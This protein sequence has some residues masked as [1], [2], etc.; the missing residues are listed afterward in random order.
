LASPA[1]T[2]GDPAFAEPAI[3]AGTLRGEE[4]IIAGVAMLTAWAIA[5]VREGRRRIHLTAAAGVRRETED[6]WT[7][8]WLAPAP[9]PR[10]SGWGGGCH[11]C[12]R[13]ASLVQC[14]G[15]RAGYCSARCQEGAWE[16]HR[17]SC[18]WNPVAPLY[19]APAE[20]DEA[21][22]LRQESLAR[23][24]RVLR[25]TQQREEAAL[26]DVQTRLDFGG[27]TTGGGSGR[28][29]E[30]S[31][32]VSGAGD[33]LGDSDAVWPPWEPP[34]YTESESGMGTEGSQAG[35][36]AQSSRG[37]GTPGDR[38][39][40]GRRQGP[41]SGARLAEWRGGGLTPVALSPAEL[42]TEEEWRAWDEE[43]KGR[44]GTGNLGDRG[45]LRSGGE[46]RGLRRGSSPG[47]QRSMGPAVTG[48][49]PSGGGGTP[50]L[51][52]VPGMSPWSPQ[53]LAVWEADH[54]GRDSG[55][56]RRGPSPEGGEED[57]STAQGGG[58]ASVRGARAASG[59]P[60]RSRSRGR[61]GR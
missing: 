55:G 44:G 6:L 49:A 10:T 8:P 11:G 9:T 42:K 39:G 46:G 14:P 19:Y 59:R 21:A 13:K 52:H 48:R 29:R 61:R 5:E 33:Y 43:R 56:R 35:E 20:W 1:L 57:P 16:V 7:P 24:R 31:R 40:R 53:A 28:R 30:S 54:K 58:G 17:T 27:A 60:G 41:S 36:P 23:S 22:P 4:P 3:I 34:N 18:D 51:P 37:L 2:V 50:S 38:E 32:Y 12:S 15:C 45:V 25:R 47:V 26:R